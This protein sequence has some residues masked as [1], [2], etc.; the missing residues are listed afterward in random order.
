MKHEDS[1]E[2]LVALIQMNCEFISDE[3][4]CSDNAQP[5]VIKLIVHLGNYRLLPFI[6][7]TFATAPYKIIK[8]TMKYEA[9]EAEEWQINFHNSDP[10]REQ[11]TTQVGSHKFQQHEH[12][13]KHKP[14]IQF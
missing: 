14:I 12:L 10:N 13:C 9:Q 6:L 8:M 5:N 2:C 7:C 1:L 11:Q 4:L 3:H